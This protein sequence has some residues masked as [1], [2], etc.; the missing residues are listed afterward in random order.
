MLDL[1]RLGVKLGIAH[2]DQTIAFDELRLPFRD[3]LI[4]LAKQCFLLD[5]HP[6]QRSDIARKH[7]GIA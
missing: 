6:P 3:D 2:R 1:Q 4:A 5:N 7:G